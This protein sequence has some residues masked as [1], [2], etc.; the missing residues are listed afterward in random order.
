MLGTLPDGLSAAI[1]FQIAEK[2]YPGK[3]AFVRSVDDRLM[4]LALAG[5]D[6]QLFLGRSR[7]L[8]ALLLRSLKYGTI[9]IA[10]RRPRPAADHR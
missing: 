7:G 3:L 2:K 4:H 8:S 6:F 9:P 1:P 10:P 5:A